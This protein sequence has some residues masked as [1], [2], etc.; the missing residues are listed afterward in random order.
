MRRHRLVICLLALSAS[1]IFAQM[2]PAAAIIGIAVCVWIIAAALLPAPPDE[3]T[4]THIGD[5]R[6]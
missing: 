2:Q 3:T 6:E 5:H 1:L 4:T